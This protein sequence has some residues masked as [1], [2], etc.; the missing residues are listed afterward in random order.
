MPDFTDDWAAVLKNMEDAAIEY[1]LVIGFDLESSKRA[2]ALAEQNSRLLT[3]V[4]VHP[5]DAATVDSAAV[6]ELRKLAR[7]PKVVAI[8]ETGLDFYRNLS[9]RD[10]QF[11]AFEAHLALAEELHLPVVIHDRDAHEEAAEVISRYADKLAGGVLHCFS[12]DDRLAERALEWGFYIAVGGTLTYPNAEDLRAVI[13]RVPTERLVLET[14]APYLA[15]QPRRGKRNEPAFV[16]YVAEELARLKGLSVDDIDRITS[17]NAKNLFGLPLNENGQVIVYPIRDSLYINVTGACTNECAFC[18]RFKSPFVKGHNLLL[19]RDPSAEEIVGALNTHPLRSY[20]E[21]VF[22]G[23]GEPLL[24][25]DAVK[26]VAMSLK[27]KG[28]AVRI[29]TNGQANLFYKRNIVPELEGLVDSISISLNSSNAEKYYE[30]CRPKFG[31]K[32]FL[33]ILD[34]IREGKKY[35]PRV[36]VTALDIDPDEL[37]ACRALAREL[38]VEFRERH[39]NEVG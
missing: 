33:S 6:E 28:C 1:S 27:Q 32:T 21:I 22:C 26:Q 8:G 3:A 16:R 35:I 10:S 31:P 4:G 29:N 13:K 23:L 19:K 12:G 5:H 37:E 9:P 17:L 20:K 18:T 34:F 24:R 25:L 11:A 39:Y 2:V 14:D 15:P 36:S 30:L 38:G 7:H